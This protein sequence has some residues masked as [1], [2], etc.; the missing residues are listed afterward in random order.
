VVAGAENIHKVC[1]TG[2]FRGVPLDVERKRPYYAVV[3]A[4]KGKLDTVDL[5][6][7]SVKF[8]LRHEEHLR[9]DFSGSPMDSASFVRILHRKSWTSLD[10]VIRYDFSQVKDKAKGL[11][12]FAEILKQTPTYE[13]ELEIIDRK[14]SAEAIVE[15]IKVAIRSPHFSANISTLNLSFCYSFCSSFARTNF[16]SIF[17]TDSIAIFHSQ[18]VSNHS[19]INVSIR[20][21]YLQSF[22]ETYYSSDHNSKC[23]TVLHTFVEANRKSTL[24]SFS[25]TNHYSKHYTFDASI[26]RPIRLSIRRTVFGSIIGTVYN[27]VVGS[28]KFTILLS[29]YKTIFLPV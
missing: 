10:G 17:R 15:S 23:K 12:T 26:S 22:Y 24:L 6:D 28:I 29:L 4:I 1:T 25:F 18:Y 9:K 7:A 14:K 5:P 27:S 2:S 13:L 19:T 16:Q 3:T 11:S 21:S 8:T 20:K